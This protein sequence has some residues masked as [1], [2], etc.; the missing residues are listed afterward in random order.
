MGDIDV[1]EEMIRAGYQAYLEFNGMK[2]QE[3][4]SAIYRAMF[5][6]AWRPMSSAPQ[7]RQ[8]IVY[9]PPAHGLPELMCVCDWHPDAGFCVDDLR[10]PTHWLDWSVLVPPRK[11]QGAEIAPDITI[12]SPCPHCHGTKVEHRADPKG[13]SAMGDQVVHNMMLVIR[14]CPYCASSDP[15]QFSP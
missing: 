15:I 10:E 11:P 12:R 2:T 14:P 5:A 3:L 8:I 1:T 4:L 13:Y 7:D 6:A 9:C